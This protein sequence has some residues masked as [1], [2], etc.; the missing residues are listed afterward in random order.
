MRLIQIWVTH[1]A[2][3]GSAQATVAK[4]TIC[5][6]QCQLFLF[7]EAV[8]EF[9]YSMVQASYISCPRHRMLYPG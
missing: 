9:C 6:G 2:A 3:Q 4:F 1:Y 7:L 5:F 8:D